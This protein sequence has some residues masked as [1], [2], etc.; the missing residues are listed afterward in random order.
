MQDHL[1]W[2]I[3][4]YKDIGFQGMV[5][6][7]PDTPYMQLFT[8]S[9]FLEK[10]FRLAVDAWGADDKAVRHIYDPIVE[11]IKKEVPNEEHQQ[12]YPYPVWRVEERVS[13]LA[14]NILLGEM[15]VMEWADHMKGMNETQLDELAKS[16]SFENCMKRSGLNKVLTEHAAEVGAI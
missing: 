7:S 3:W 12:L 1:S 5:Y 2:S 9:G 14:R 4:L 10:K 6:V 13:R 11:F 16:F 15:M 8:K